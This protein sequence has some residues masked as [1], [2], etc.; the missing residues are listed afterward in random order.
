MYG[1]NNI[2]VSLRHPVIL[3]RTCRSVEEAYDLLRRLKVRAAGQ[4]KARLFEPGVL[5]VWPITP[6]RLIL[7]C[8]E[9]ASKRDPVSLD[10]PSRRLLRRLLRMR[11]VVLP[12]PS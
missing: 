12:D 9:A 7:R 1:P 8:R 3:N 10:P 4:Q 11:A 5:K 6:S 2:H